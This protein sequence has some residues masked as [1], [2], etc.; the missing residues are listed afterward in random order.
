MQALARCIFC[1]CQSR[2][3]I[4]ERNYI[5]A[6]ATAAR[7]KDEVFAAL[8]TDAVASMYTV[9]GLRKDKPVTLATLRAKMDVAGM[10]D[11]VSDD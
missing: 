9:P 1:G 3:M 2:Q 11:D 4:K 6:N 10:L 5:M 7:S 8:V